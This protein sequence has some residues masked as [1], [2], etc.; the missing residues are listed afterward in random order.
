MKFYIRFHYGEYNLSTLSEMTEN[1]NEIELL[2]II[3]I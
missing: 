2:N 3:K 1:L